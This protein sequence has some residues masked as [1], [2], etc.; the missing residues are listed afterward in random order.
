VARSDVDVIV[1]EYGAAELRAASEGERAMRLIEVA[2]P[3]HREGL[4]TAAREMG[5]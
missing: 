2:A 1:T 5:L 4:R 3:E